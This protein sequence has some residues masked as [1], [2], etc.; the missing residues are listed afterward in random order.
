MEAKAIQKNIRTSPRKLRL[1]ANVARKLSPS[2]AVEMLPYSQKRAAIPL[3]KTIKS[4]IANA[5]SQGA[6]PVDLKF[7]EIQ[8]GEGATLKRGRPV[9]R[10]MWHP[11]MKRT[12]HIR[13]IV[14][15][16]SK[17]QKTNSSKLKS[18]TKKEVNNGSKS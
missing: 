11:I 18:K 12:S 15:D 13:I 5:V 3:V 2:E 14:T 6:N 16:E 1:V 9:S 4:A 8:I 17:T 10:G 7:K